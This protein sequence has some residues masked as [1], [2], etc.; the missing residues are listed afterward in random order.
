MRNL[1]EIKK[2]LLFLFETYLTHRRN[3]TRLNDVV[4]R[5]Q[6]FWVIEQ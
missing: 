1:Q 5:L 2:S 4:I 6:L 3:E